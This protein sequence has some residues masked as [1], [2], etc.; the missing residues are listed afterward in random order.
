MPLQRYARLLRIKG[1]PSSMLVLFLIRLPMT[2][3]GITLTLHVVSELGRGYGAAGL[4]GTATTAGAALGAPMVGRLIDRY[5][6]RP[7]V[8]VCGTVSCGYWLSTPYLPYEALLAAALVAGALVVPASSISR[9]VLT[10]LV[11]EGQRRTAYSLD[12]VLLE[13][14][15]MVGPAAW[16]ALTTQLSSTVAL[17]SLG[18]AFGLL[19]LLLYVLDP[20]I[21]SKAET[22]LPRQPRPPVRSWLSGSLVATLLVAVGALFVLVGT[23]LAA[24]ATL[25]AS[26]EV[27][28]TGALITVMC[29]ASLAGGLVH[30][31]VPRSLPQLTLMVLLAV[32]V[33][34]VGLVT[35][36]WWLLALALVPM[37]FACAPTLAATTEEVSRLVRAGVRGEAMGLQDM[38]T[39]TG[40]A[41][42]S[43]VVGFV[44][45][46]T[47]PGWGFVAAGLGGVVFA[48]AG[49]LLSRRERPARATEAASVGQG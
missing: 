14:S 43:P 10:A 40:L 20:P 27:G 44:I 35:Q 24:L 49:V 41:L 26:G 38:A 19:S 3:T 39:K 30:G 22:V 15:F 5:G 1:V 37:N 21:R 42:G 6:L 17:T 12:M 32:L 25:R 7:V 31:A 45:D 16:I 28:W 36:P 48:V 8:A 34:P 33:L 2:A 46:N 4:V 47:G 29:V 23:E 9:Q 18:V 13:T 11:P